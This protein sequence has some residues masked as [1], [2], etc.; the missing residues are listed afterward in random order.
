MDY[1]RLST[2]YQRLFLNEGNKPERVREEDE[3]Q[4]KMGLFRV[5]KEYM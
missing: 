3:K 5:H 4:N 1:F 2:R